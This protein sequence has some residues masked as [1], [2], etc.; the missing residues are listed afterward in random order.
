MWRQL[1]EHTL[2]CDDFNVQKEMDAL[3]IETDVVNL[4]RRF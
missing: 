4:P 2:L 1:V 3:P